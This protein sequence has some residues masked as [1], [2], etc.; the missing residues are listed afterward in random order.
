MIE[1]SCPGCGHQLRIAN[2]FVGTRGKCKYCN[3]HFDVPAR[4]LTTPSDLDSTV[5]GSGRNASVEIPEK[6]QQHDSAGFSF[7]DVMGDKKSPSVPSLDID[8]P[9]RAEDPMGIGAPPPLNGPVAQLTDDTLGCLFWGTAFFIPP[10]GLIWAFLTP[11]EHDQR[12]KGLLASAIMLFVALATFAVSYQAAGRYSDLLQDLNNT[13]DSEILAASDDSSGQEREEMPAPPRR[14]GLP[15]NFQKLIKNGV[16]FPLVDN[17][18]LRAGQYVEQV[19]S[20]FT[21]AEKS[22][23]AFYSGRSFHRYTSLV[24]EYPAALKSYG[25]DVTKTTRTD[26]RGIHHTDFVGTADGKK[27]HLVFQDKDGSTIFVF[28]TTK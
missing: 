13:G 22:N 8:N 5:A 15:M 16:A 12:I 20:P 11:A 3:E 18:S 10:A 26:S 27:V 28:V 17:M 6:V 2:K 19:N 21:T 23:L 14:G 1:L 24:Q 4:I 9:P 7:E 25:W